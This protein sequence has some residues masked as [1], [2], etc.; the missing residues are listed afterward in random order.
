MDFNLK[1]ENS[2]LDDLFSALPAEYISWKSQ[3]EMKGTTSASFSLKGKYIAAENLN[4]E[5]RFK[6][7]VRDGFVKNEKA[8]FPVENIYLNLD[9]KLPN[10]DIN[11][12]QFN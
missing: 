4:P 1:T 11:N 7:N 10:L 6:I 12:Y 3:T 8:P 2:N 5:V 9:T